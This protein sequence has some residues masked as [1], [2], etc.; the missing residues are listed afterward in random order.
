M[1]HCNVINSSQLSA[2]VISSHKLFPQPSACHDT[3]H[4][5]CPILGVSFDG[6]KFFPDI[7]QDPP[8]CQC[9]CQSLSPRCSL[10]QTCHLSVGPYL[11]KYIFS[12]ILFKFISNISRHIGPSIL[13]LENIQPR[14]GAGSL[15]HMDFGRTLLCQRPF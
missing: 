7:S 4:V 14:L 6:K 3:W 15:G 9:H 12:Q 2:T 13:T 1:S 10:N 8:C 11:L 5:C